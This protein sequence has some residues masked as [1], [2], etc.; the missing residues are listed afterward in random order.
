[1]YVFSEANMSYKGDNFAQYNIYLSLY[2]FYTFSSMI[3]RKMAN[4]VI[5]AR[6][7]SYQRGRFG[8]YHGQ[9]IDFGSGS[10]YDTNYS[11]WVHLK[12]LGSFSCIELH[13]NGA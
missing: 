3:P 9:L 10:I 4:N 8:M 11:S 13:V 7:L 5:V 2:V 6:L 1:M 12:S